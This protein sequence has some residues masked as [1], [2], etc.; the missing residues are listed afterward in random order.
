MRRGVLLTAAAVLLAG[1]TVL[2]F[3][4]GG[5]FDGPRFVATLV[6]WVLVLVVAVAAGRPIPA[7][8]P[9]RVALAGMV[10]IAV[11]T[12]ISL[13][14]APLSESATDA[15]VRLLLY[16]GAL[17]AAAGLLG[18]RVTRWA[19]EPVLAAGV[20]VVIGY[21]LSGRLLP[22]MIH[23]HQSVTALGR[24]EQPITY[25]NAEGALAAVGFVLCARLAGSTARPHAM[26]VAA[27]AACAPLGMG[28]Y[29]T[30]SRG[31]LAAGLVGLVLLLAIAPTRPQLRAAAIALGAALVTAAAAEL[32]P[33]VSSLEGSIA[34]RERDGA[35]SL[36]ILN[37]VMAAAAFAQARPIRLEG[38]SPAEGA[39]LAIAPRL[40]A[41]GAVA[42]VLAVAVLVGA[43]IAEHGG[44]DPLSKRTGISRLGSADSR[45]YDYWRVGIDAFADNPL[46]GVGA[47]GFRAE[48]VRERPVRDP[49]LE[50]HSLPLEMLTELGLPGLLAFG[51]LVGGAAVAGRRALR[52]HPELA[53]GACAGAAVW[54]LHA[55]IDW[56]WQLPAVTLPAIVLAGA[57]IAMSE[58]GEAEPR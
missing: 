58:T 20:L 10:L 30:Y 27:A 23:L 6:A 53:P 8:T 52:L 14:W 37:V 50:V 42:V 49:A 36:A 1:P 51:L 44:G 32:L 35:I 7:S 16:T 40:P 38:R 39:R 11:W 21:G 5:Y 17:V 41:I 55:T 34:D 2:A 12:A 9:G 29:L 54:G 15:L 18:D 24:L 19:V 31:A 46:T 28:V 13:T 26:R 25:W 56:D 45:R 57:L 3:Y 48:W 4:S 33:G 47:G 43:A 22:G